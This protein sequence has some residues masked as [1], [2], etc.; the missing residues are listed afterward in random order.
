M[1]GWLKLQRKYRDSDLWLCEKFT[2]GQAWVDLLMLANYEK[3]FFY[4]RGI[5]IDVMPGQIA[6]SEKELSSRWKWS[7]TKVRNFLKQLEKEQ[8]IEQQ[9]TNVTQIVTI[10][11][12][13]K[14]QRKEQQTFHQKDIK[15]T[16]EEHQ[17][18]ILK[19]EQEYK[20]E[21][22]EKET[23]S[24]DDFWS[25]YHRITNLK[26]TDRDSA[27]KY[28][29][30]LSRLEKQKALK[31]INP[32]FNNCQPNFNGQRFIKKARTYLSDKNFND[33]FDGIENSN[34]ISA[35]LKFYEIYKIPTEDFFGYSES[36]LIELCNQGIYPKKDPAYA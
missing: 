20:E 14:Y 27:K 29:S 25:D 13:D 1:E 23:I 9:L 35:E 19:E 6:R 15:K 11:N 34:K 7:R 21:K 26:K 8:Q 2:R 33:E 3:S 28:W 22:E 5:K 17:K 16:P 24:F 36:K 4:K 18:N 30:K 32:Y 12:F 10:V 31:N